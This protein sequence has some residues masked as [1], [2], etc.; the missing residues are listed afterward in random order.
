MK[1]YCKPSPYNENVIV[2][3]FWPEKEL[4]QDDQARVYAGT[5]F[6]AVPPIEMWRNDNAFFSKVRFNMA[7]TTSPEHP[8]GVYPSIHFGLTYDE[9][10]LLGQR[11]VEL[12]VRSRSKP[13]KIT[14]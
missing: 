1:H 4:S 13:R 7:G 2:Y 9:A 6:R 5:C 11:L 12:G 10:N 3:S 14:L 8:Y